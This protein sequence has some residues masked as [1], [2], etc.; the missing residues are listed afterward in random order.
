MSPFYV[1]QKVV[2]VDDGGFYPN[3]GPTSGELLPV[4]SQ[5]YTV[6]DLVPNYVRGPSIRL[7]EIANKP[8]AYID[9]LDG[10]PVYE[11]AFACRRFR[12]VVNTDIS[13]FTAMLKTTKQGADA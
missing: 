13:I 11:C 10:S 1:G 4:R 2:C 9:L 8:H 12:P 5:V 3:G 7:H 6:R